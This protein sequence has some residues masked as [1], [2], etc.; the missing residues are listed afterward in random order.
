M[1]VLIIKF[2]IMKASEL[3]KFLLEVEKEVQPYGRTL[4][5][6]EVN[7]RRTD[8]SDVEQTDFVGVDLFDAESN[9]IIES[10]II[11]GKY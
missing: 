3:L 4:E 11:M 8:D 2:F 5:D 6:V 1:A 10:V 7:Y 9:K